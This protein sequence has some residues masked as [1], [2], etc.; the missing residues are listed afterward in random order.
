MAEAHQGVAFAFIVTE[1]E[2]LHISV[3]FETFKA[4]ILS[5]YRSWRR[6]LINI[7]NSI[8]NGFFPSHPLRGLVTV[9]LVTGLKRYKNIDLSFGTANLIQDRLSRAWITEENAELAGCAIFSGTVFLSAVLLRQFALQRLLS[10]HGWMYEARNNV[11]LKT[12]MWSVLVKTLVGSHPRLN[13]YQY[14]LPYLP[15]PNLNDTIRKYL[16]SVRPLLDDENYDRIKKSAIDFQNGVGRRLQRYLKL[17]HLISSNYVSDW[18]EEYVYLRGRSPIMV[19]SNYYGTDLLN[20]PGTTVQ[21][22]R[23]ANA[24]AAL[25]NFRRLLDK[26]MIKPIISNGIIPLCSRQ[27]ERQFNTTRIPGEVADRLVHLKD[28]KHIA[29]FC[30]GKWFKLHTY[31][32]S[33]HM[34]AK[35]IELQLQ[36]ILDDEYVPNDAEK[37]VGA[38]TAGDRVHWAQS[39]QRFFSSRINKKS[40]AVIEEAAFCVILDEE[41]YEFNE[42]KYD[43]LNGFAQS[44]LYGK[45]YDRWFDKSFSIIVSKN[46]R[47]GLNVEHSWADAPVNSFMWEHLL[48]DEIKLGYDSAGHCNGEV[49]FHDLVDPIRLKWDLKSKAEEAI[50][51]SLKLSQEI[52]NDVDLKIHVFNDFG[53]HFITKKCCVSPDAFIQMALQLA[54]FRDIGKHHLTYE[55]SMTRLFREGRTETVRACSIESAEWIKFMLKEDATNNERMDL[56]KKSCEHHVKQYRDAMTGKGIDRHIFCLYVVSKY[57]E[58]DTP[59]LK[60]ILSEP[61][62]LS[63]S[64]IPHSQT[65]RLEEK[66]VGRKLASA[67]GGFGP[68]ADDGYG[69]CYNIVGDGMLCFHISSKKSSLNTDSLRFGA[70]LAR[71]LRD[72][73]SM[74]Q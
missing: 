4:V 8:L 63:T 52:L 50:M 36:K 23:A 61:W 9:A 2:G 44:L 55:A 27:H 22:A 15:V 71:S 28:S 68:V 73:Q 37:Y 40:L 18:W 12:K 41:S 35:E 3:R 45:G 34:N 65:G 38:L 16:R 62:R 5:G 59:F 26:Q 64:Q 7:I 31:N 70:E 54:Y 67:G 46:G 72:I 47:I 39:R 1:E 24:I 29:V 69:V 60:E 51:E 58:I 25:F 66:K 11:S 10:Y 42:E 56:F 48:A 20:E 33:L 49:R 30:K 17:K 13:S 6:L 74:F 14:L 19:N 32:N 43:G 57:L 21:S 53:K